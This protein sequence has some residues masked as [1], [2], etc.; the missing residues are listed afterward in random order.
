MGR[1]SGKTGTPATR[2]LYM[3][4]WCSSSSYCAPVKG[5]GLAAHLTP[6]IVCCCWWWWC[7]CAV[8]LAHPANGKAKLAALYACTPREHKEIK[9]RANNKRGAFLPPPLSALAE[10]ELERLLRFHRS[11]I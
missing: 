2:Y 7:Y 5:A 4:A 3:S 9:R 1:R 11:W 10:E 8:S 6:L